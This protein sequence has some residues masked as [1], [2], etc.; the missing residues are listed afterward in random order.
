[1]KIIN[2]VVEKTD[3]KLKGDAFAEPKYE[4]GVSFNEIGLDQI[5]QTL[6]PTSL[7]LARF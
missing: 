4:P 5:A 6:T 3:I 1:L 2:T 7:R